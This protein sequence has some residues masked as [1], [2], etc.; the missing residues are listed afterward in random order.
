MNP[1]KRKVVTVDISSGEES[2]YTPPSEDDEEPES[3]EGL[4]TSPKS[5]KDM[6]KKSVPG[7][8]LKKAKIPPLPPAIASEHVFSRGKNSFGFHVPPKPKAGPSAPTK[9][10]NHPSTPNKS[11]QRQST[12]IA[13]PSRTPTRKAK[14][15]AEEKIAQLSEATSQ[16]WAEEP[17]AETNEHEEPVKARGTVEE[18]LRS[19]SITPAPAIHRDENVSQLV[20]ASEIPSPHNRARA[21]SKSGGKQKDDG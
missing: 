6:T 14:I 5:R 10:Q 7:P 20:D 9:A 16:Y 15:Q 21:S 1:R 13:S 11:K 18:R 3:P 12:S 17:Y 19:M 8:P 2:D 4:Q